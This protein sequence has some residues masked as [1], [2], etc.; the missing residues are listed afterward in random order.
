MVISL[1]FWQLQTLSSS[2]RLHLLSFSFLCSQHYDACGELRLVIG[3][4]VHYTNYIT[5]YFY[6]FQYKCRTIWGRS[7][8]KSKLYQ[9]NF[10]RYQMVRFH[11]LKRNCLVL[12]RSHQHHSN[13]R[14]WHELFWN[15]SLYSQLL[16]DT[17]KELNFHQIQYF[18]K[19]HQLAHIYYFM[20]VIKSY[21]FHSFL[22][23]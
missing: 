23:L 11:I 17:P 20:K 13:P 7:R 14:N 4:M 8:H 10:L 3:Y 19:V 18:Y 22:K 21:K 9:T 12:F 16:H 15:D 2:F 1:M 6:I 5:H